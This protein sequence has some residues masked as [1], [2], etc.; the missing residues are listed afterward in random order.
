MI[1]LPD[2]DKPFD[3]ENGFYLTCDNTRI[4]KIIA[5]YELY[6]L[7]SNLPGALVECG[8][9]KGASLLRFAGFRELFRNTCSHKIIGFDTFGRFPEA[10]FE[11]SYG[12]DREYKKKPRE[13]LENESI[14]KDQLTSILKKKGV[15][16]NIELVEGDIVETVPRYL[17][18]HPELRISLL[19]LDTDFYEPAVVILEHL[20]DRIVNGG[21]MIA[22]NYGIYPG[23][24]EAVDDYFKDKN[25]KIEKYDFCTTP[26]YII[27]RIR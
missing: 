1:D 4:G 3:Y 13:L 21:V 15:G 2:F 11:T 8:V 19:N 22:D 16:E 12:V 20:W 5:H 18:K 24:T 25:V 14:S 10:N 7:T 26:C 27:K 9:F 23:E 6:K 17:K